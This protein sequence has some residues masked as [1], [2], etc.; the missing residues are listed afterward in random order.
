MLVEYRE[1][2]MVEPR[3]LVEVM[4]SLV[5]KTLLAETRSRVTNMR[6]SR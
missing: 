4:T 3:R 5:A 2:S 6:V 1:L